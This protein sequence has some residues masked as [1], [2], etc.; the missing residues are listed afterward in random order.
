[1][2]YTKEIYTNYDVI[3]EFQS[4]YKVKLSDRLRLTAL[5][6]LES[7][8]NTNNIED[9]KKVACNNKDNNRFMANDILEYA[10]SDKSNK[11]LI[12]R[13]LEL[14]HQYRKSVAEYIDLKDFSFTMNDLSRILDADEGYIDRNIKNSID[15]F[16]IDTMT[17]H[18]LKIYKHPYKND[19]INK[20]IFFSRKSVKEF[21]LKY[22]KYTSVK[23]QVDLTMPNDKYIA[24]MSKFKNE[25]TYKRALKKILDEF[26]STGQ[27]LKQGKKKAKL[28]G[29]TFTRM[30]LKLFNIDDKMADDIISGDTKVKSLDTIKNNIVVLEEYAHEL[31]GN[32]NKTLT[33]LND[34]QLYRF[35]DNTISGIRF[36]LD[37]FTVYNKQL[38]IEQR[39]TLV[40]YTVKI[41]DIMNFI[42]KDDDSLY[43]IDEAAYKKIIG[44]AKTETERQ[45]KITN[46]FY[47]RLIDPNFVVKNNKRKDD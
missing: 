16:K 4:K 10:L 45:E 37:G 23:S 8:L 32:F 35:V 11:P 3:E 27:A 13:T 12:I 9:L 6:A 25:T 34:T 40:R 22:F 38:D 29:E 44:D 19:F 42:Q 46:Y 26:D 33:S 36:S 47:N 5:L 43:S 15:Y 17:R 41:K 20:N 39:K 28:R 18:A 24:L 21:L 7:M 30:D 1:M 2:D 31:S 14:I